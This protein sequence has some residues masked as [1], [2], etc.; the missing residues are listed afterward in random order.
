MS[1]ATPDVILDSVPMI[2][3]MKCRRET[4]LS[5]QVPLSSMSCPGCRAVL[6]VPGRIEQFVVVR[7]VGAGAMGT[8]FEALDEQLGR[9]VAIKVIHAARSEESGDAK[10]LED[11][12]VEARALAAVN[13]R[14]VVLVH[15]IG[16]HRGQPY[17]VMELVTGKQ[18]LENLLSRNEPLDEL[19][20]LRLAIDVA[21]GLATAAGLNLVHGDIKPQNILLN[22]EGVAKV[23]DFGFGGSVGQAGETVRGTPFYIAPERA[24]GKPIDPRS[25]MFSLGATLHHLL[26][27]KPPFNGKNVMEVVVARLRKPVPDIR[28]I[29]P[30]ISIA[31]AQILQRLMAISPDDRYATYEALLADLQSAVDFPE[32][33][34]AS[35]PGGA[36]PH[37]APGLS[38][39]GAKTSSKSI[40]TR[41]RAFIVLGGL[42]A[43]LAAAGGYFIARSHS[44]TK[45][46]PA[47]VPKGRQKKR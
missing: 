33:P 29:R 42:A 19:R 35:V 3:C 17:I 22:D 23:V 13:H 16:A 1:Q 46:A 14:N 37:R 10:A 9:R 2:R 4:M 28:G 25:D 40:I 34:I 18:R 12:L 8:V 36:A 26:C 32:R 24:L 38:H 7:R 21:Q 15:S 11:F 47:P 27:A 44:A 43:L 41:R 45:P 31:T 39:A 5:G 20:L 6:T 30:E